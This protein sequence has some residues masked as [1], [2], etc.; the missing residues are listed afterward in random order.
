MQQ[1]HCLKLVLR[2]RT[3]RGALAP[4]W[5]AR[6]VVRAGPVTIRRSLSSASYLSQSSSVMHVGLG[7]ATRADS[8]EIRWRDDATTVLRNIESN[9]TW[10]IVDGD[11]A[12]RSS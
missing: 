1:G 5:G 3:P 11:E 4:A 9:R 8:V 6:V 10:E 7:A 2:R 12:P